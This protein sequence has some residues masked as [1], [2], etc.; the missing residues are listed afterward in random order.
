MLAATLLIC[1]LSMQYA[2][3]L[4]DILKV[5]DSRISL[6]GVLFRS[7]LLTVARLDVLVDRSHKNVLDRL[8]RKCAKR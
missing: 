6:K 3:H 8:T 2:R 5:F 1:E 4:Y 7:Y